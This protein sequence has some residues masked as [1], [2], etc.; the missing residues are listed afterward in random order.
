MGDHDG[1]L[2]IVALD[3]GQWQNALENAARE[4]HAELL[5]AQ[6]S[7]SWPVARR[8][9]LSGDKCVASY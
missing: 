2:Y 6:S 7:A 5:C 3:R 8:C 4:P 9:V 1:A